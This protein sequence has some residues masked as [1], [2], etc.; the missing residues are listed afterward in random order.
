MCISSY[1]LI[2]SLF[3]QGFLIS[4]SKS[5]QKAEDEDMLLT[6]F[7]L[8]KA[9]Q[10]GDRS[11]KSGATPSLKRYKIEESFSDED[12]DRKS[13]FFDINFRHD[14]L[15]HGVPISAGREQLPYLALKGAIAFPADTEI[16]KI[17]SVQERETVEEENSA[18]FPIGR[19][20][21]DMLRCMLGRVYRPC[22][23][24]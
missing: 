16:Q 13:K 22:W 9:L 14:F 19:R 24:V 17:E 21:F 2:L 4:V 11:E 15:N 6:A 1:M 7:N 10:N 20:D 23:Q 8:G 12:G 5:L 3:S 18:K